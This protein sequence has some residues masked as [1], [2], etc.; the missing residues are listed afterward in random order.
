MFIRCGGAS[1]AT[2]NEEKNRQVATMRVQ[3]LIGYL[4]RI[5]LT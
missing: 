3:N 5:A 4:R 1:A 2:A